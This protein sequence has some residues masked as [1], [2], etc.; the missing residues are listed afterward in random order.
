LFI[1]YRERVLKAVFLDFADSFA[2][3]ND[4]SDSSAGRAK[5]APQVEVDPQGGRIE[6][7]ERE[8]GRELKLCV[9]LI[10]S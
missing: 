2:R 3:E 9:D 7:K 5:E 10:A 8:R 1:V 4:T 6:G